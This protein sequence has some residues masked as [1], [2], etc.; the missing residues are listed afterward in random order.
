MGH[1]LEKNYV[2]CGLF[3]TTLY[4]RK[5]SHARSR[6]STYWRDASLCAVMESSWQG[7]LSS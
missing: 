1:R 6:A 2:L 4:S 7:Q 5:Q 3:A